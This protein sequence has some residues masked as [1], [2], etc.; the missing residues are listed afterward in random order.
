MA[1][2]E[3]QPIMESVQLMD[4][5]S[6]NISP[7]IKKVT[8][9]IA[10]QKENRNMSYLTEAGMRS[11]AESVRGCPIVGHFKTE[12]DD[13]GG[14]DSTLT[15]DEDGIKFKCT[16][17]PYGFVDLNAKVWKQDFK[18]KNDFGEEVTKTCLLTEGYVWLKQYE[19]LKDLCENGKTQSMELDDDTIEGRWAAMQNGREYFII[20]S[21]NITKLCILGDDVEPAF[22]TSN[23][24]P[25]DNN[26]G[27]YFSLQDMLKEYNHFYS[28]NQKQKLLE[29]S[30]QSMDELKT[31]QEKY[32][33]LVEE[34][35]KIDVD[36]ALATSNLEEANK[37]YEQVN[38]ELADTKTNYEATKSELET[39]KTN[40]TTLEN[41]N[42]ELTAQVQQLSEF[43][44]TVLT[45]A[46]KDMVESFSSLSEEE[47]KD[48]VDNLDNY[49]L[50]E[51]ES[52]LS[53]IYSRK[54]KSASAADKQEKEKE[55]SVI[56]AFGLDI[57]EDQIPAL[58]KAL[59]NNRK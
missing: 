6:S 17:I 26:N 31:L 15:I 27:L 4:L 40:Y 25:T 19:E 1:K 18:F 38:K 2:H 14:H 57:S 56:T 35:A 43:Q 28:I 33:K 45:Q 5:Q 20:D 49:S 53:V 59:E 32:N 42:N 7:F 39:I 47:K 23:V 10:Y 50:E 12:K 30:S 55:K 3:I 8:I 54:N 37:K 46:K 48:V 11:L 22:E 51:V 13:F 21:A 9:N 52:K 16:T 29:R 41:K 24:I 36:F 58:A 44:K 34:K